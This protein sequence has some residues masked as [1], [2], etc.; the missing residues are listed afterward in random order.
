MQLGAS[1]VAAA[2]AVLYNVGLR[3]IGFR[4]HV[5][6]PSWRVPLMNLVAGWEGHL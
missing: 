1:A 3:Y 4:I 6:M 5:G 2:V